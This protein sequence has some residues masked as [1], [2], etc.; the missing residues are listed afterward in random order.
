MAAG[1]FGG[2]VR[3]MAGTPMHFAPGTEVRLLVD[4]SA[5]ARAGK[6]MFVMD[7]DGGAGGQYLFWLQGDVGALAGE[8]GGVWAP[9]E[10]FSLDLPEM[11]DA[12]AVESWL[13]S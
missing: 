12:G 13:T 4:V 5:F 10:S 2:T 9:H 11:G 1:G 7:D 6:R 3:S 8:I